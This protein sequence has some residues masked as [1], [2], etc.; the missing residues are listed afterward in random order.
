[1]AAA[2]LG[3]SFSGREVDK[4]SRFFKEGEE[5]HKQPLTTTA[6][7]GTGRRNPAQNHR[8]DRAA[9]KRHIR[10]RFNVHK[11]YYDVFI[12]F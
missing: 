3:G 1:M 10:F 5:V 6:A 8:T 4:R 11:S 12:V 9:G 2:G 7:R